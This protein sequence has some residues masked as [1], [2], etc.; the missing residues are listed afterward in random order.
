MQ[1]ISFTG[2]FLRLSRHAKKGVQIVFDQVHINPEDERLLEEMAEEETALRIVC[3]PLS[4]WG[5][6]MAMVQSTQEEEDEDGQ[7]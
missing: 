3:V 7:K 2:R 4:Q 6:T 5:Q 1:T